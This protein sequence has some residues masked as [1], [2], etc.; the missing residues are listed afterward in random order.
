MSQ[1]D[2]PMLRAYKRGEMAAQ[3]AINR[4]RYLDEAEAIIAEARRRERGV[5]ED[6]EVLAGLGESYHA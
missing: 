3:D 6:A 4:A 5:H 2:M 1:P